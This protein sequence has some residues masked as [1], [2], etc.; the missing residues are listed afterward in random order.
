M[1]KILCIKALFGVNQLTGLD[2][3]GHA[4][5][6]LPD[7]QGRIV[8]DNLFLYHAHAASAAGRLPARSGLIDM[9]R[10]VFNLHV[11]QSLG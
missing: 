8:I 5:F 6:N 9:R 3:F 10:R 2:E 11:I 4:F 7:A 1:F